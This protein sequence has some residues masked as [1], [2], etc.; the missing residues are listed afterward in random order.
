MAKI[1]WIAEAET[2]LKDIFDYI[3]G[4]NREAAIRTIEAIYNKV[5]G[6][7]SLVFE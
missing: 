6:K 2:W 1:N 5:T 3:S 7:I 4:D